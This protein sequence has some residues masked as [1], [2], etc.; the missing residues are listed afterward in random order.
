M[1]SDLV[2]VGCGGFGREVADLVRDINSARG[3]APA[4]NLQGFLDDSPSALDVERVQSMG[5]SVLGTIEDAAPSLIG[6]S[7]VVGVGRGTVRRSLASRADAAGLVAATLVHPTARVGSAVTIGEGSVICAGVTV[8]TNISVGRH[9]HLDRHSTVGHD[10]TIEEFATIH[11]LVAISGNCHIGAAATMG[12]HSA[13]LPGV[14]IGGEAFVGGGA[15]VVKDVPPGDH[16][17]RC[18]G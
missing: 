6:T 8:T 16:C 1:T 5:S 14:S 9:V 17:Q 12:T 3:E 4:W 18:A 15:C 11:P 13:V 2:I 7:Y 10:S